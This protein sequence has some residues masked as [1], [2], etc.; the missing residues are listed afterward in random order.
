[1]ATTEQLAAN[2]LRDLNPLESIAAKL[3]DDIATGTVTI[4]DAQ[5]QIRATTADYAKLNE[6]F[7]KNQSEVKKTDGI[8][9]KF[10]DGMKSGSLQTAAV[11][12][13]GL[14]SMVKAAS[15]LVFNTF[16]GSI[17]MLTGRI[18]DMAT[19]AILRASEA[20]QKWSQYIKDLDPATKA[21]ISSMIE[22][23][24]PAIAATLA[25]RALGLQLGVF[26]LAAA[27]AAAIL[28]AKIDELNKHNS[29]A[30]RLV[31]GKVTDQDIAKNKEL[32]DAIMKGGS[33]EENLARA[34]EAAKQTKAMADFWEKKTNES[35]TIFGQ[36]I[37]VVSNISRGANELTGGNE[38]LKAAQERAA[39]AK[40]MVE[41]LRAGKEPEKT[42]GK[43]GGGKSGGGLLMAGLNIP[44]KF[45]QVEDVRRQAQLSA[46]KGGPLEKINLIEKYL[47]D[48]G[49]LTRAA[50]KTAENTAPEAAPVPPVGR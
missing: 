5:N 20:I 43:E 11:V 42:S 31:Q 39:F 27:A 36:A 1:M 38:T 7:K 3:L 19:P 37:P 4:K 22:M 9:K 34:E 28:I 40:G 46:L 35:A 25:V 44:S 14:L 32:Y 24:S 15:P 50:E 12:S 21:Q 8:V 41:M 23:A 17:E 48:M 6:G 29:N 33:K 2:F 45:M 49:A 16:T 13:A 10:W 30:Q 18:G 26:S 47:R